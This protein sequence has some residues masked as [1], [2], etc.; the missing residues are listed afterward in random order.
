[1][2]NL[3][4]I[5]EDHALWARSEGGH[6]ANLSGANLSGADLSRAD[7][8]RADLYS[9]DLSGANLSGADLSGADLSGANLSGADLYSANLSRAVGAINLG[10]EA[11]GHGVLAVRQESSY[12]IKAGCRWFTP[13]E[14]TAHWVDNPEMVIRIDALYALA[15]LKGW[16]T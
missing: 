16:T 10:P 5:L 13:E 8:S 4:Q 14:A 12:R 15:T 7:L 9:A 2:D 11:R 1:M 3:K 6:R